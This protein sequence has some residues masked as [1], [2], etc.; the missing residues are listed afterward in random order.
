MDEIDS[1]VYE[2]TKDQHSEKLRLD[3]MIGDLDQEMEELQRTLERKA[4]E[5]EMLLLEKQV[6]ERKIDQAR[7]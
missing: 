6:H 4:K 2:Q 7:L 1:Q 3:Q 5:K